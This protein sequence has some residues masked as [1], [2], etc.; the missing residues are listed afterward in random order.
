[1]DSQRSDSI[2]LPGARAAVVF[3]SHLGQ[4]AVA[5][6]EGRI[7][8]TF[9]MQA[10]EEFV[11]DHG[12]GDDD[13]G[14]AGADA[15]NLSALVD[16]EAGEA[17]GEA[18]HFC[19]G[20]DE[21]LAGSVLAKISGGGGESVCGSRGGDYIVH[22]C[23]DHARSDAVDFAGDEALQAFK[24]AFAGRIVA[25]EFVGETDGA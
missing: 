7:A 23:R 12:S 24:F 25:K 13:F 20:D 19:A 3:G 15:L 8:K 11:I 22:F 21:A 17:F 6:A 2:C 1:M 5:Q 16:G 4:Q 18:R 14:A 10:V 9:E